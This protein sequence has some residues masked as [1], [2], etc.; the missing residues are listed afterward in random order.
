MA[1][2]QANN[3][4]NTI[5][6]SETVTIRVSR[7]I[8]EQLRMISKENHKNESQV[9]RQ[10]I[11]NGLDSFPNQPKHISPMKNQRIDQRTRTTENNWLGHEKPIS[12][13]IFAMSLILTIDTGKKTTDIIKLLQDHL[14]ESG[15][16]E[17]ENQSRI[18]WENYYLEIRR[19]IISNLSPSQISLIVVDS[20]V[21]SFLSLIFP[22]PVFMA[23][24]L[25]M[26]AIDS[27][28]MQLPQNSIK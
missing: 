15:I 1:V 3:T 8:R 24:E 12:K 4:K 20:F 7:E 6:K 25:S 16:L 9:I 2:N 27:Y 28:D 18:N 19:S 10:L 21:L 11:E 23:S 17:N 26:L 14:N 13:L 22:S 5:S